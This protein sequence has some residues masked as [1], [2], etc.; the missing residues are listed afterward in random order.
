RR[1]ARTR[2]SFTALGVG[3]LLLV[4]GGAALAGWT[5]REARRAD[6]ASRVGLQASI[7]DLSARLDRSEAELQ[8]RL[9][10]AT[11]ERDDALRQL[12]DARRGMEALSTHAGE[13]QRQHDDLTAKAAAEHDQR[14]TELGEAAHV[15]S[16]LLESEQRVAGLQAA[17][18][19][20]TTARDEAKQAESPR[21]EAEPA[22]AMVTTSTAMLNL[23]RRATTVL[24]ASG[25][26]DV[27]LVEVQS[28]SQ[29]ALAGLL[30]KFEDP[31]GGP[32]RVLRAATGDIVV[33][34]G[35]TGL[36]LL[37]VATADGQPAPIELVLLPTIDRAAW[38]ALG[39]VVPADAASSSRLAKA[40]GA[41]LEPQGWH[42][43]ELR[44]CDA[45]TLVGL[46]LQQQ[47]ANGLVTRELR[48]ERGVLGPGELLELSD[49]TLKVG[50]D[51]RP[52]YQN[53]YRLPLPGADFA[54]WRATLAAE[55][56]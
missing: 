19:G 30:V 44:G 2:R 32:A 37:D 42:V 56:R 9:D 16:Q 7:A 38:E 45:G 12:A 41:L 43:A 14:L 3:L 29:G 22:P 11:T 23:A 24:H 4:G 1:L 26:P 28:V 40:L 46:R 48:A 25:A 13:L 35:R 10:G 5:S 52:F 54:A 21:A 17:I 34:R 39:V 20:V 51:E 8:D 50:A 53:V 55:A 6:D 18:A 36:R 31:D 27:A 33:D 47:D 49:G 15:R